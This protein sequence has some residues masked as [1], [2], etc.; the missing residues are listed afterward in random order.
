MNGKAKL[1]LHCF[2]SSILL[3]ILCALCKSSRIAFR[4][5]FL[6]TADH[7]WSR[8]NKKLRNPRPKQSSYNYSEVPIINWSSV[9]SIDIS[10]LEHGVKQYFAARN[11]YI[12]KY[13]VAEFENLYSFV[14]KAISPDN[15]ENFH[16]FLMS[17]TN[18]FTQNVCRS[19]D[20]R[21]NS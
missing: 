5:Y 15:K 12:K 6:G 9:Q 17:A 18:T 19:K 20:S 8:K 4:L 14:D 2:L 3:E 7:Q 1:T 11:K 21:Y 16:E 10:P 13:I